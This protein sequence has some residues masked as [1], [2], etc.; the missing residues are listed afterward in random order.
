MK[1]NTLYIISIALAVVGFLMALIPRLPYL[2]QGVNDEIIISVIGLSFAYSGLS[3]I[4]LM[5]LRE[6][7]LKA[8]KK[9]KQ[10]FLMYPVQEKDK[11]RQITCKLNELGFD[12]WFDENNILPGQIIEKQIN[13]AIDNSAAAILLL[14]NEDME[15]YIRKEVEG[16]LRK[17]TVKDENYV[18]IIPVII[19]D[20]EL[21]AMLKNIK[22]VNYEDEKL[23][24]KLNL[25]LK[26]I[27]G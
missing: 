25:S 18:P 20:A 22:S 5:K 10:I 13:Q 6:R 2:F 17:A 23:I 8:V 3:L 1:K 21:P 24:D 7:R 26:S 14:S 4:V 16:F 12:V 27:L 11:A 15:S 9:G 19:G